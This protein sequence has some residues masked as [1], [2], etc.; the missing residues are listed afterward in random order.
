MIMTRFLFAV[1]LGLAEACHA[2]ST[3]RSSALFD[4]LGRPTCNPSI[5]VRYRAPAIDSLDACILGA[6]ARRQ[7]AAGTLASLGLT[8]SDSSFVREVYVIDGRVQGNG[9]VPDQEF[10]SVSFPVARTALWYEVRLDRNTGRI[11]SSQT[12]PWHIRRLP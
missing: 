9:I 6:T 8:P 3:F 10:W 12:E 7:V 2:Q 11:T 4:S 1:G 5:A